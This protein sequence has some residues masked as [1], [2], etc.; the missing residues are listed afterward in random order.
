MYI[1]F[2]GMLNVVDMLLLAARVF[3]FSSGW[4]TSVN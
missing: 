2:G 1:F 3:V 4:L